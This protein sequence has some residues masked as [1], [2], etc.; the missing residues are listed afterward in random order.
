[1]FQHFFLNTIQLFSK[2]WQYKDILLVQV[3]LYHSK[4]WQYKDIFYGKP[5]GLVNDV[6]CIVTCKAMVA[7]FL[8][9]AQTH[10]FSAGKTLELVLSNSVKK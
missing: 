7:T 4:V 3:T 9:N 8:E 1:M 2:V 10:F 6:T 5:M